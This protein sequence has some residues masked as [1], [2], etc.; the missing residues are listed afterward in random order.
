MLFDGVRPGEIAKIRK[1]DIH[2]PTRS[3]IFSARTKLNELDSL[4]NGE[5]FHLV[6]SDSAYC[7]L[8]YAMK[9]SISEYVFSGVSQEKISES[10]VR[11]FL[12]R[13]QNKVGK[14]LPRKIMRASFISTAQQ[15][16]IGQY[17][18]KVLSNHD[19]KGQDVDVT[20]GYK[21]TY[22]SQ[23]RNAITL[24]ESDIYTM[25][26]IGKDV[27]CRGLLETLAPLDKKAMGQLVAHS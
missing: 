24:V 2:H 3:I 22:L 19:G 7:Q 8:L 20:D 6:L 12:I 9:H 13:V 1:T 23:V 10:S 17:Y 26:K 27:V 15:A 4:K 21:T 5:E 25:S 11:D 14:S 18:T 16:R